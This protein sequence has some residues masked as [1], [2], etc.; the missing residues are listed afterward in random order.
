M[1]QVALYARVSTSMQAQTD[2]IASQ[3]S[4]LENRIAEDGY[5]LFDQLK[6][7]DNGYSGSNLVR[8]GL[9]MLRDKAALGDIDKLYVHSPDRLSRKYAYQMIL[10]EELQNAGVEITFLN[11]QSNDNP[12]S[13]LLL[14]M[15]GMI[16]EYERM[17]I[18]ERSRRGKIFMAKKGSVNVLGCA[19]YGYRYIDLH[20]G[21]GQAQY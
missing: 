14:Q 2:T 6:F 20:A 16:A 7:I 5:T 18:L 1:A 13:Q 21:G 11:F 10:L 12:E 8:P 15:Q 4:A 17:K 3:V 9:E 19:P